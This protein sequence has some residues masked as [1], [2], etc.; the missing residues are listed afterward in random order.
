MLG[1]LYLGACS[2]CS[3]AFCFDTSLD[4]RINLAVLSL[5]ERLSNCLWRKKYNH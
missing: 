5:S 2:M 3:E 4:F 1:P